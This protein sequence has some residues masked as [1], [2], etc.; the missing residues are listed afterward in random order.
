MSDLDAKL[1]TLGTKMSD[2]HET[3]SM[4]Y[5][6]LFAVKKRLEAIEDRLP[7]QSGEPTINGMP[8]NSSEG[9]AEERKYMTGQEWFER[10]YKELDNFSETSDGVLARSMA[11]GAAKLASGGVDPGRCVRR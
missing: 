10:F 9:R 2:S 7:N 3:D 6:V 8:L 4:L 5:D 1:T 11:I